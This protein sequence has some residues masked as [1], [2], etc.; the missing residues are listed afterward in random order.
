MSLIAQRW[1][2]AEKSFSI[3]RT[4]MTDLNRVLKNSSKHGQLVVYQPGQILELG[5]TRINKRA[6]GTEQEVQQS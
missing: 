5:N 2:T 4:F 1:R 3:P 6:R